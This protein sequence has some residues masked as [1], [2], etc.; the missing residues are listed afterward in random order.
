MTYLRETYLDNLGHSPEPIR[1]GNLLKAAMKSLAD[2][3]I[4]LSHSHLDI[5]RV[6]GL[7]KLLAK[8]TPVKLYIDSEDAGMPR[9]TNRESAERIKNSISACEYFLIL[10]TENAMKSRWVPWEI[11]VADAMKKA[12]KIVMLPLADPAGG[13]HG[14]EYLQLYQTIEQGDGGELGVFPPVGS[15]RSIRSGPSLRDWLLQRNKR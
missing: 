6:E 5:W 12:N 14:N 10:G 7:R 8:L 11:G 13:F 9:I 1:E 3:T 2:V 4:F 15:V